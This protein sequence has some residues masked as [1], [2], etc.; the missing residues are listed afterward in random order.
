MNQEEAASAA[1]CKQCQGTGE[2]VLFETIS[3]RLRSP[4]V[5]PSSSGRGARR[6]QARAR[7]KGR[8]GGHGEPVAELSFPRTRLFH[9][10][11]IDGLGDGV[12]ASRRLFAVKSGVDEAAIG[13]MKASDMTRA[14]IA[15][16]LLGAPLDPNNPDER[17][18]ALV[19][20]VLVVRAELAGLGLSDDAADQVADFEGE[21]EDAAGDPRAREE[22]V[23]Q[24][25]DVVGDPLEDEA[26]RL[27]LEGELEDLL[28]E[29]DDDLDWITCEIVRPECAACGGTG[30]PLEDARPSSTT[31]DSAVRLQFPIRA[32]AEERRALDLWEPEIDNLVDLDD[33]QTTG[34][35]CALV[36]Q[37]AR[38]PRSSVD[39]I[40]A[41]DLG[42]VSEA[43]T[44]FFV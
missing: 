31:A 13:K 38:I 42:P 44:A 16:A 6:R 10:R 11:R 35:T 7:R 37:V 22:V 25:E 15:N 43:V 40:D 18:S 36:E 26:R 9:L 33:L 19:G 20:R 41:F 34:Q 30:K 8:P 27:E 32:H 3:V 21:L 28:D 39:R 12:E 29:L 24:L 1:V 14:G 2:L 4:V 17:R 23:E 5:V